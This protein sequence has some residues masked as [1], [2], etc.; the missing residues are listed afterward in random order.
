VKWHLTLRANGNQNVYS[1][2]KNEKQGK[3]WKKENKDE[4]KKGEGN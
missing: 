3:K 1:E 4:E 2:P